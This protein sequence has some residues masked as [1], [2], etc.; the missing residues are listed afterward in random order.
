MKTH[1][2]FEEKVINKLRTSC[3]PKFCNN[4]REALQGFPHYAEKEVVSF[5]DSLKQ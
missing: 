2:P 5:I 3:V 4:K 1:S